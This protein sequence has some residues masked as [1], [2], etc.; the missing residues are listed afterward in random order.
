MKKKLIKIAK[1]EVKNL[2]NKYDGF[3]NII[4]DNWRGYRLIFDTEKYLKSKTN[5]KKY[6]L[7]VVLKNE[8][9]G[10]FNN[11]LLVSNYRDKKMFGEGKYLNCR[12]LEE[13]KNCYL[14][15][16]RQID[17]KKELKKELLLVKNLKVVY[18]KDGKESEV[19]K[20]FK[21]EIL[22]SRIVKD[23]KMKL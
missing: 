11:C 18:S 10:Y 14:N 9:M 1:K 15:F 20:K 16:I 21:N 23:K 3:N 12:K 5:N 4:L 13:Y 6:K 8:K 19:E 2:I 22:K 17:N 7:I